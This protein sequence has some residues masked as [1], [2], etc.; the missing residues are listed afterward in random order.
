V[1]PQ[2]MGLSPLSGKVFMGRINQAGNAFSGAKTDVTSDFL[3]VV[4]EK[5]EFH[6]GTFEI[7]AGGRKWDVTV[8]ERAQEGQG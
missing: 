7:E 6:G 3:R 8:S 5:A 1:K 2:R 4:I